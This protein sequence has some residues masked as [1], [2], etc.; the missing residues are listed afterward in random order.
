MI[1]TRGQSSSV[2]R[3]QT[4]LKWHAILAAMCEHY[5]K[6]HC[7]MYLLSISMQGVTWH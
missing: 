3:G 5:L 4:L 7:K 1:D 6:G 2:S